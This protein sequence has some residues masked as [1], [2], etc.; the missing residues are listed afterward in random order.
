MTG[1]QIYQ[2]VMQGAFSTRFEEAV[3]AVTTGWLPLR[4]IGDEGAALLQAGQDAGN[5]LATLHAAAEGL[6]DIL[7]A[8]PFFGRG[9]RRWQDGD[10]LLLGESAAPRPCTRWCAARARPA[11]RRRPRRRRGRSRP[12]S[13]DAAAARCSWRQRAGA[14]PHR[15]YVPCPTQALPW[16]LAGPS[17]GSVGGGQ[18]G[19]ST[20]RSLAS[21]SSGRGDQHAHLGS[22]WVVRS[23]WPDTPPRH[24]PPCMAARRTGRR[25][26]DGAVNFQHRGLHGPQLLHAVLAQRLQHVFP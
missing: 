13:L 7:L 24:P 25:H 14:A 18:P 1:S 11:R 22:A 19:L 20:C 17:T 6:D 5:A 10:V 9:R 2:V 15:N 21:P 16:F 23:A 4:C 8:Y 12:G 3:V 26:A